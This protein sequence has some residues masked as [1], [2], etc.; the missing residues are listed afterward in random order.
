METS[1]VPFRLAAQRLQQ[2]LAQFNARH[3][4]RWFG[5]VGALLDPATVLITLDRVDSGTLGGGG[6]S[7]LN[8]GVIAA[9]FDAAFVLAG[10]T[11]YESDVVVTLD[12]SVKFLALASVSKPLAFAAVVTRSSRRFCFVQGV[13]AP[14][15]A[16]SGPAFATASG[17]VA[18]AA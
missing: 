7:A 1:S 17:M 16:L 2:Q 4:V 15:D 10:L 11:Q 18:P 3:E 13:L 8:G 6:T 12:L 9:G 14:E 5:F